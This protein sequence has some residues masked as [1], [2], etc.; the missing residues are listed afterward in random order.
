ME[1]LIY[2]ETPPKMRFSAASASLIGNLLIGA[3]I[4]ALVGCGGGSD[5][6]SSGSPTG[7]TSPVVIDKYA[8]VPTPTV[9]G[10]IANEPFS[11]QTK[12]YQFFASDVSLA[13]RGYVEEEFYIN[14][15]A[16]AY[17]VPGQVFGP[18]T[19]PGV[20]Q[21]NVVAADVPYKTRMFVR[22][23]SDP[24]KFNGTVVVEWLNVTDGFD[25]EYF[26][27]Q[28][29]DY[30]LRAGYAYIGISAQDNSISVTALSLKKFSPTRYGS[31]DVTQN[32]VFPVKT[33][34]SGD[35]L[36]YDIYSQVAK[37]ARTVPNVLKG[38]SVKNVLGIGMSQSGMRM[39]GYANYVHNRANIYDAFLIQVA[40]QTVRDDL[41]VPLI[42]VLSESE[43]T[44]VGGDQT[45]TVKRHTWWV[46][47]TN[48]G[49][50]IQRLGRT[51]VRLRDLGPQN[52]GNDN[53][54]VNG[55]TTPTRSRTPYRHVLNAAIYS[56][57]NQVETGA[58]PAA[59][60]RFKT[61]SSGSTV[62]VVRDGNG[63]VQGGI[64]LAHMEVPTARVD[65][66]ICGNVGAWIPFDDNALNVMYTSHSDYVTKVTNAVGVSVAAGFVLAEDAPETIAEA[67]ASVYGYGLQCGALCL[68]SGH[69]RA[70]FSSTGLLRDHTVYYNTVNGEALLDAANQAH[71]WVAKGYS[72]AAASAARRYNFNS[73][74]SELQRYTYL[75]NQA[76]A[77]KKM[78]DT[79]AD[80]LI[81]EANNIISGLAATQ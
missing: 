6:G 67:Q 57:K 41:S 68:S 51:G 78:T 62:S 13:S 8:N 5:G 53:C 30:L 49:D 60:P 44:S 72:Q 16:N 19:L 55:V 65:G 29:K 42:K 18:S 11:S 35:A 54:I 26:W 58:I 52:T 38:L 22:R 77:D 76:R 40:N 66:V 48:H 47:G 69:F 73:A 75:V 56:L 4:A 36:S 43:S 59:G 63:N 81:S 74:T 61:T 28:A 25:G 46:A 64:R 14:G 80:L 12:N 39:G 50:A 71:L 1:G 23:P 32:G 17:D 34:M 9:T 37:A 31:L 2:L 3:F 15:K 10:P 33:D 7:D 79:A 24:A 70:D 20:I 27:V 45:D 21:T